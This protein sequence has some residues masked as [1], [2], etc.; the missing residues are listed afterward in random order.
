MGPP[1]KPCRGYYLGGRL[2]IARRGFR[3]VPALFVGRRWNSRRQA[4]EA[5][6]EWCGRI[7]RAPAKLPR[8]SGR[9]SEGFTSCPRISAT[10]QRGHFTG[11]DL[12]RTETGTSGWDRDAEALR[13][14]LEPVR[15]RSILDWMVPTSLWAW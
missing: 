11:R 4:D 6:G 8:K 5:L 14:A 10:S 15:D 1:S 3:R 7:R 12:H 13:S 9:G 2:E